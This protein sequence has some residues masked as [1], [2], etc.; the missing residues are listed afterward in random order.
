MFHKPTPKSVT[1]QITSNPVETDQ[2]TESHRPTM[3]WKTLPTSYWQE[4]PAGM[5][6][7]SRRDAAAWLRS[8]GA[9]PGKGCH[10]QQSSR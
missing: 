7:W 2:T 8:H 9:E 1:F 10:N 6:P 3:L 5:C 4:F